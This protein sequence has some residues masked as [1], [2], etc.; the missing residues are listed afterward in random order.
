MITEVILFTVAFWLTSKLLAD[1][2]IESFWAVP[3]AAL[4]YMITDKALSESYALIL[5]ILPAFP[6]FLLEFFILPSTVWIAFKLTTALVSG[7]KVQS[8]AALFWGVIL[9][10]VMRALL[11]LVFM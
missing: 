8:N 5:S 9:V 4:V 2:K 7:Y 10:S 6:A 3:V 1:I 11:G